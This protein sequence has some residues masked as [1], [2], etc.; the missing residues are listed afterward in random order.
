ML[1]T[2][3]CTAATHYTEQNDYPLS[4]YQSSRISMTQSREI[5]IKCQSIKCA[6]V[7]F[8]GVTTGV[9]GSLKRNSARK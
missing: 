7:C 1:Y 3:L 9:A 8:T 4:S 6:L 5:V 2:P